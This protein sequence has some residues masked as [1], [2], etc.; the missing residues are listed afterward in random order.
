MAMR[1][2]NKSS[3]VNLIEN[4]DS[5]EIRELRAPSLTVTVST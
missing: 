1:G 3:R 4:T 2:N 5:R